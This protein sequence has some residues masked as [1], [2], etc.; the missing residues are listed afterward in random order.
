MYE[1]AD[2]EY[3]EFLNEM[4]DKYGEEWEYEMDEDERAREAFLL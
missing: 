4:R 3:G 2:E 1:A